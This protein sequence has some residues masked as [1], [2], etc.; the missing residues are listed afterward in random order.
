MRIASGLL[1][2]ILTGA[3]AA[4]QTPSGAS[5]ASPGDDAPVLVVPFANLAGDPA[6]DW[7]GV[8]IAEAVSIDLQ[9]TGTPVL[10][11]TAEARGDSGP[12]GVLDAGR[13]AGAGRVVSGAYQRSG[14]LIRVTARLLDVAEGTV[15]QSAT[16]T[17]M[18]ADIF[19]LQDRVAAELRIEAGSVESRPA[20]PGMVRP[21]RPAAAAAR[22]DAPAT[23]AAAGAAPGRRGP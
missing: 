1:A 6:D 5:P 18:L 22:S 8:G 23:G 4:A 16:V 14:D 12:G 15:L 13:Q 9:V 11:A 2:A 10:R 17:G 19:E 21:G 20:E 7:I 3:S